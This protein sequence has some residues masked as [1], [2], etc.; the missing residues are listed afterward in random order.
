LNLRR[1]EGEAQGEALT[2]RALKA[3]KLNEGRL[4]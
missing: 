1:I 3:K 2:L 4:D